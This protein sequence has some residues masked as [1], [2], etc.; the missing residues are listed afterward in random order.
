MKRRKKEPVGW[1]GPSKAKGRG[2]SLGKGHW[3]VIDST[4]QWIAAGFTT[5][6]YAL[7]WIDGFN[8]MRAGHHLNDQDQKWLFSHWYPALPARLDPDTRAPTESSDLSVVLKKLKQVW[9]PLDI[10][11]RNSGFRCANSFPEPMRRGHP[12]R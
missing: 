8:L 11:A 6:A 1:I 7:R 4:G 10:A 3:R 12:R 9:R 2:T 5:R